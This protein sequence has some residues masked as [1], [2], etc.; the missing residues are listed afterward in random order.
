MGNIV[1]IQTDEN[2]NVIGVENKEIN[3][4]QIDF[5][6]LSDGLYVLYRGTDWVFAD[7][8]SLVNTAL[9]YEGQSQT[10]S[11]SFTKSSSITESST[12]GLT[13]GPSYVKMAIT[14]AYNKT[15][16]DSQTQTITINQVSPIGKETLYKI[17][18]TYSRYDV[19]RIQDGQKTHSAT[20][21][22]FMGGRAMVV[23]VNKGQGG[24][25]DTNALIIREDKCL[26]QEVN[27]SIW[28]IVDSTPNMNILTTGK[29]ANGIF[30]LNNNMI[31]NNYNYRSP[32]CSKLNFIF[33]IS[34][35]G[36][37][38]FYVGKVVNLDLSKL[39]VESREQIT[40]IELKKADGV[41]DNY[42]LKYLEGGNY[43]ITLSNDAN[44]V[45]SYSLLVQK[46]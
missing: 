2:G 39:N 28:Q 16:S 4:L 22:E 40:R 20:T 19:V 37:Y 41:N 46:K 31:F 10:F 34:E 27:D 1:K 15:I 25:I 35:A 12:I 11:Q 17:Y 13:F 9:I 32:N 26:L 23:E 30:N 6:T 42:I 44:L 18:L 38:L 45:N 36:Q 29:N 14:Q 7:D 43:V 24:A 3:M 21:Y 5:T 8:G 33:N